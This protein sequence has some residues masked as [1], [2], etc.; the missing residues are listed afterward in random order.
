MNS[1][2]FV[3]YAAWFLYNAVLLFLLYTVNNQRKSINSLLKFNEYQ[4]QRYALQQELNHTTLKTLQGINNF[5][6][7]KYDNKANTDPLLPCPPG[8]DA[9]PFTNQEIRKP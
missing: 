6:F 2:D 3:L 9:D 5:L 7:A 1:L 8:T 4:V